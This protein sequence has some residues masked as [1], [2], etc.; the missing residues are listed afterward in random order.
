M[1]I[2]FIENFKFFIYLKILIFSKVNLYYLFALYKNHIYDNCIPSIGVINNALTECEATLVIK[3]S[4]FVNTPI[5]WWLIISLILTIV[6]YFKSFEIEKVKSFAF[7]SLFNKI[8]ILL[9]FY[10]GPVQ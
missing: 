6:P 10:K 3:I 4:S 2:I 5:Y 7:E 9:S 1:I 8:I